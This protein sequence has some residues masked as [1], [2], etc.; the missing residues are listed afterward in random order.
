MRAGD[1]VLVPFPYIEKTAF[2]ERPVVVL[3]KTG[4]R[5]VCAALTSHTRAMPWEV[6]L[7]HWQEAGLQRPS[8]VKVDTLSTFSSSSKVYRLGRLHPHDFRRVWSTFEKVI[9][10][11]KVAV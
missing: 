5:V 10:M 4:N 7:K 2:K 9:N 11:S 8:K 1:V 6:E 3:L